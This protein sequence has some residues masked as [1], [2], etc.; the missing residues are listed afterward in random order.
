[1][2]VLLDTNVLLWLLAEPERVNRKARATLAQSVVMLY[3]SAA[4]AWEIAIKVALGK[5]DLGE[6]DPHT[7]W[8]TA[9]RA[10]DA[11]PLPVQPE[12]ALATASLPHH[13]RDPFDR[14]LIAQAME[15][16]LTLATADAA[17]QRYD[18]PLLR[19]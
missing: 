4:S 6:A 1:M 9:L 18:V 7:W 12:H 16:R 13:H 14:L 10:L 2:R 8:Q 5:L 3:A 17:L 11:R 15:A 19:C